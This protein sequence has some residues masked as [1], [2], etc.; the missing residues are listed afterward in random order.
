M[1]ECELSCISAGPM[2]PQLHVRPFSLWGLH[3]LN[4]NDFMIWNISLD[5][6][7]IREK[8]ESFLASM[9]HLLSLHYFLNESKQGWNLAQGVEYEA[10]SVP[11]VG[12]HSLW[13]LC[14]GRADAEVTVSES[15]LCCWPAQKLSCPENLRS[16]TG[17]VWRRPHTEVK[18]CFFG[19]RR[20]EQC[21]RQRGSCRCMVSSNVLSSGSPKH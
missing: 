9:K 12:R 3:A 18:G 5:V 1:L 21:L 8:D 2:I 11:I 13:S 4:L 10:P 14:K 6:K 20:I 15:A 17:S 7:G 19:I 16:K